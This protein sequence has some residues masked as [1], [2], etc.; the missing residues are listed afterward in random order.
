[1][2]EFRTPGTETDSQATAATGT[3]FNCVL[4][5]EGS[6]IADRYEVVS[7]LGSGGNA[8]VY[9]C[10][11]REL[12]RD[13][14]L[15]LLLR[16]GPEKEARLKREAA[17]GSKFE[18]PHLLRLH[19]FG[20][21]KGVP[22]ITMP[23]AGG[24]TLSQKLLGSGP[25]SF[26]ETLQICRDILGGLEF[27]HGQGF[28]HRDIK[29]SNIFFDEKGAVRLGD[30]GIIWSE[31]ETRYTVEGHTPGTPQYM[32]PEF[33][34]GQPVSFASN[35]WSL[36]LTIREMLGMRGAGPQRADV[37]KW[38][39]QWLSGLTQTDPAKRYRNAGEALAA[40]NERNLP[41][42]IFRKRVIASAILAASVTA[43]CGAVLLAGKLFTAEATTIT[44][45]GN[46]VRGYSGRGKLSWEVSFPAKVQKTADFDRSK[47]AISRFLVLHGGAFNVFTPQSETP[48]AAIL[49][50]NGEIV[51]DV[52][53]L[54]VFNPFR[55]KFS[56]DLFSAELLL[57]DDIDMD[58]HPE[59]WVNC[60]HNMYPDILYF[61][62]SEEKKCTG[63]FANS[64]HIYEAVCGGKPLGFTRNKAAYLVAIN[65]KM[66]HQHV[67][68]SYNRLNGFCLSPDQETDSPDVLLHFPYR[69][70][71]LRTEKIIKPMYVN[72][73]NQLVVNTGD[74]PPLMM[75][76]AG[77]LSTDEWLPASDSPV[78]VSLFMESLYLNLG[79]IRKELQKGMTET[80]M[81]EAVE[82]INS[83]KDPCLKLY[84][85]LDFAQA[86]VDA[87]FPDKAL[88][89][90]PGD[91]ASCP[92]PG[93]AFLKKG[94]A[95][96]LAGKYD[97]AIRNLLLARP[98]KSLNMW[99]G[100]PGVV[101]CELMKG[102]APSRV[103]D[104]VRTNYPNF[105]A[106]SSCEAWMFQAG[107]LNGKSAEVVEE[108]RTS[109]P[110]FYQRTN[111]YD[112]KV[113]FPCFWEIWSSFAR[114]DAGASPDMM[115]E[116]KEIASCGDEERTREY[117]LLQAFREYR[118]G[119]RN[120]ALAGLKASF[121]ELGEAAKHE[122]SALVPYV[123]SSYIFGFASE[124]AGNRND[125]ERALR[126]A[127]RLYPRGALAE[128][129][130]SI[131][132]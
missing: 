20:S 125:S 21:H 43:I 7:V 28:V 40:L 62:S 61:L 91:P 103:Y 92:H 42:H 26:Q 37:P 122:S 76:Q 81:P 105:L 63:A 11:D 6:L 41:P 110:Q 15:K 22:F 68:I 78:A 89:L 13:V 99:Y 80:G 55:G 88:S 65:N 128:K 87:G 79:R 123:I 111:R 48:H 38:F 30:F 100:L 14:A 2:D 94:E 49:S 95:L 85:Q 54:K 27:L 70:T 59:A 1:M 102:A 44:S 131:L 97:E 106:N 104:T 12:R 56:E 23:V 10:R 5:P 57:V 3:S 124:E 127:L 4:Y 33:L 29:P 120:K 47:G 34:T 116:E 82:V 129:A 90:L 73:S 84:A 60:K 24:G 31:N 98:S 75:D 51:A 108:L 17:V 119:D 9:K 130:R 69:P 72:D 16:S 39:L 113:L 112:E 121:A 25:L 52:D 107:I 46:L 101:A 67:L 96:A 86:L 109:S 115:P 126:E 18:H 50:A 64:G 45:E 117:R 66:G 118:I 53:L 74:G 58:G 83:L 71:S 32:P 114:I 93:T 19:D 8:V 35:L 132:K 77:K 36:G